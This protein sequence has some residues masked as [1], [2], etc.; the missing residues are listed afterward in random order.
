MERQL[1]QVIKD[2]G[3][4]FREGKKYQAELE[5]LNQQLKELEE[6]NAE[7]NRLLKV[8]FIFILK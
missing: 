1:S 8:T 4:A 2:E 5:I 6:K 7:I 3:S